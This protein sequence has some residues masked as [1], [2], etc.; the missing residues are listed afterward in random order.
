MSGNETKYG[1]IGK[2]FMSMDGLNRGPTMAKLIQ[3]EDIKKYNED[4]LK[5]KIEQGEIELEELIMWFNE[6]VNRF[7]KDNRSTNEIAVNKF[8]KTSVFEMQEKE[9][10]IDSLKKELQS[11]QDTSI[12]INMYLGHGSKTRRRRRK[13]SKKGK[14]KTAKGRVCACCKRHRCK[15]KTRKNKKKMCGC[16]KRRKCRCNRKTKRRR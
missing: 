9:R 13:K 3:I 7:V 15:C 14:G 6:H 2:G 16:C 4:I 5:E 12:D 1:S 8:I 10:Q 11:T